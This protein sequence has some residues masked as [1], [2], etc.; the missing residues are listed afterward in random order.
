VDAQARQPRKRRRLLPMISN[1]VSAL[2]SALG[3]V[4]LLR[5]LTDKS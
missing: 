2:R 5:N 3:E 4:P 1:F